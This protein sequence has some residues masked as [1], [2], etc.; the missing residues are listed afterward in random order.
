MKFE[1]SFLSKYQI[2][3]LLGLSLTPL[4]IKSINYILIGSFTPLLLFILFGEFLLFGYKNSSKY[5]SLV[6]K[7]WS[8]TII[9]WGVTRIVLMILFLTTSVQEA[10]IESQFSIWYILASFIHMSLGYYLFKRA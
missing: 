7:I 4:L 6:V 3:V 2:E 1:L 9:L 5:F 10:H 8:S